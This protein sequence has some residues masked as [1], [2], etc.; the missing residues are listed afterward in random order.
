MSQILK[1][2]K[3]LKKRLASID[4]DFLNRNDESSFTSFRWHSSVGIDT[5]LGDSKRYIARLPAKSAYV[6]RMFVASGR[7]GDNKALLIHRTKKSLWKMSSDNS[8]IEPVFSSDVLS[9]DD[10]KDDITTIENE[11]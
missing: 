9:V 10:L 5:V 4:N 6:A 2:L 11:G 3:E 8:Y 1:E 7:G